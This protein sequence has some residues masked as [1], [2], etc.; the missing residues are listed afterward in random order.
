MKILPLT[1]LELLLV[2]QAACTHL[3]TCECDEIRAMVNA[4]VE[5]AISRLE[6]KLSVQIS[7]SDLT[8][9]VEKLLK[10]IQRQLDYHL[11]PP[12]PTSPQ[13]IFTE[14]NPAVSC[15]AIY[16]KYPDAET[17]YYWIK[18]ST[19]SAVNMYCKMDAN[20]TGYTGGW[21][22][23]AYID[24]RNSSHQC[25]SGFQTLIRSSNP[26]RVC[27]TTGY[28]YSS[29]PSTSFS[30]HGLS[31]RH[32]YGRILAYQNGYPVAFHFNSYNSIDQAYVFGVSLTCGRNPRKHIWTFAGATDETSSR[33]DFKCPCI[34]RHM[35]SSTSRIPSFI[36]NDLF[37]DTGFSN[38]HSS[39]G[40]VFYPNDPLWDGNGCGSNNTCCSVS[41]LCT[42]SPPWFIK[43]L[44]S[45]TTD[46]VEMRLCKPNFDGSTP[47]EIVE[48]YVQ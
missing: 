46:N 16:D 31:Y 10:P 32:V 48:L 42:K 9:T 13:E 30:V 22:R 21:M 27:D 34:N 37:C 17:G 18:N 5:E 1:I 36:G 11:P 24:M 8:A 23:V 40:R 2:Q 38:H 26:R 6:N 41:N 3:E 20:C 35:S 19:G 12:P 14:A 45:S 15:K 7:N 39:D 43:H 29:C 28:S 4:T 25:P 33:P 47:I 44:S